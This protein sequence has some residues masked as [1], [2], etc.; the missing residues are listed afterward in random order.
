MISHAQHVIE[1]IQPYQGTTATCLS[2]SHQSV[3]V[4]VRV[5]QGVCTEEGACG[6]LRSCLGSF[7]S[8][9]L[10][11]SIAGVSVALCFAGAGLP[12]LN[13]LLQFGSVGILHLQFQ[14]TSGTG[15]RLL[16]VIRLA[17]WLMHCHFSLSQVLKRVRLLMHLT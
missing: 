10:S 2:D 9:G 7:I 8:L 1:Q 15:C 3:L 6:H 11:L 16:Y 12:L 17:G 5:Q 14:A 4:H 13:R